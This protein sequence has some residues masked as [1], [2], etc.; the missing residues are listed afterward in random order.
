[1]NQ[2]NG[3]PK[4]IAF[5]LTQTS[6]GIIYIDKISISGSNIEEVLMKMDRM[7]KEIKQRLKMINNEN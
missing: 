6:K 7:L 4:E 1:M 5:S 3:I 2:I